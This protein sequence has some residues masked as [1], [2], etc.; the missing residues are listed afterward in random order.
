M[1]LGPGEIFGIQALLRKRPSTF[2]VWARS[3][4]V[5][6]SLGYDLIMDLVAT[7][8]GF[9]FQLEKTIESRSVDPTSRTTM[10]SAMQS[11]SGPS[12]ARPPAAP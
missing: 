8:P 5:L 11:A 3:D 2:D 10:R 7:K 6:V 9:A 4:A 12:T 1:R